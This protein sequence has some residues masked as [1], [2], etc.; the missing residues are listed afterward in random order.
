MTVV[1]CGGSDEPTVGT[2]S[3]TVTY[4]GK[5]VEE[6]MLYVYNDQ[7]AE[8]GGAEI[9]EGKFDLTTEVKTGAYIAYVTAIPPPP[10]NP[11]NPPVNLWGKF[12]TEIPEKYQRQDQSPLR[13]EVKEGHSEVELVVPEK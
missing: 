6:G 10:P 1:G 4:K 2:V 3:G 8:S 12:P 9:H 7:N 13:I 11:E 5:P